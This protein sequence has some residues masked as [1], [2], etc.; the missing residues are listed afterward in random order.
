MQ[1]ILDL[2]VITIQ[3]YIGSHFIR[4]AYHRLKPVP[5]KKTIVIAAAFGILA[6]LIALFVEP[7]FIPSDFNKYPNLIVLK[8][9]FSIGIIEELAKF[10]PLALFIYSKKYFKSI[11]DALFF[12]GVVGF[13]FGII[14]DIGYTQANGFATGIFR[15]LTGAPGHVAYTTLAG[16]GLALR[17]ELKKSWLIVSVY[18]ALAITLH[19]IW[20]YLAS[21]SSRGSGIR[22]YF[23]LL[24]ILFLVVI[25][26]VIVFQLFRVGSREDREN[27]IKSALNNAICKNCGFKNDVDIKICVKCAN[28]LIDLENNLGVVKSSVVIDGHSQLLLA[29]EQQSSTKLTAT[30]DRKF[31]TTYILALL[32]GWLGLDRLY[33]K[34]TITGIL[35]LI[36]L[37]GLGIW[38]IYDLCMLLVGK[39][40]D[41]KHRILAERDIDLKLTLTTTL[42]FIVVSSA[43]IVFM[44]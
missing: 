21:T 18:V 29:D 1:L 20:D 4:H 17:K 33:L 12:F 39:T 8:Y 2:L 10:L 19:A 35:K 31:K 41:K 7:L 42:I 9:T 34:K 40:K 27:K 44:P 26:N 37:G 13:V 3:I 23:A 14:E 28:P 38:N 5:P 36:T 30:S 15:I 32:F 24:E 6:V 16:Y 43:L 11:P 22:I 25:I